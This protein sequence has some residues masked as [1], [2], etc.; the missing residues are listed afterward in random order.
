MVRNLFPRVWR[1]LDL[2]GPEWD[3][4]FASVFGADPF[5]EVFDVLGGNSE[6]EGFLALDAWETPEALE[7]QVDLPGVEAK[8]VDVQVEAG[9]LVLKVSRPDEGRDGDRWLRRE[10]GVGSFTRTL[11]LPTDIDPEAVEAQ[12]GEGVLRLRLPKAP[13]VKPHT[14]QV[15]ALEG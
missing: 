14:I 7:V 3:R 9:Q 6:R 1:P 11:A 12:L 4:A 8:D 15:K 13:E 5:R 10:R 2:L